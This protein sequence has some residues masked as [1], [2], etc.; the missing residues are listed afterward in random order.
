MR[1][2][3]ILATAEIDAPIIWKSYLVNIIIKDPQSFGMI[4]LFMIKQTLLQIIKMYP[5]DPLKSEAQ[6]VL[7][8]FDALIALK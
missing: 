1:Y 5:N 7:K 3:D 2:F 6:D 4:D 8:K